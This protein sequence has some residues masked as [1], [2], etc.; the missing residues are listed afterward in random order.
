MV[1]KLKKGQLYACHHGDYAGQMFCFISESADGFNFLRMPE[2]ANIN[3]S[4]DV[5][6]NGVNK[7]ILQFVE[8]IGKDVYKVVKAQY[9]KNE[10]T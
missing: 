7:E 2:M 4:R 1:D 8:N 3:L 6:Y 10:N 9:N 5:F